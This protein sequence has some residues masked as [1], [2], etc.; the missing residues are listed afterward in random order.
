MVGAEPTTIDLRDVASAALL[1][2]KLA[3]GEISVG[4]SFSVRARRETLG[5]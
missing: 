4:S 1:H 3:A 5:I 2:S